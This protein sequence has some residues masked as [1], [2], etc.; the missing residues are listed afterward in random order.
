MTADNQPSTYSTEGTTVH[1][2]R[3][4]AVLSI[5]GSDSS[6]G[7]GIQADLKTMMACGLYGMTAITSLTAQNTT[8]VRAS[9][10][11]TPDM[12][13]AQID[14]VFKDIRP[15]AVKIGMVPTAELIE[16]IAQR[17]KYY[18]ANNIV[19]DPVMIASSGDRLASTAAV[20]ALTGHLLPLATLVTPN[21][22]EAETLAG[23]RHGAIHDDDSR[24]DAARRISERCNGCAVLIKGGH[25]HNGANDLLL[26][27]D[28]TTWFRHRRIVNPNTHGT[29]CTLSSAIAAE[30]AKGADLVTAVQ[31][32][33][34]YLT[35]CIAAGLDLGAG[36]GP[37]DHAWQ[38]RRDEDTQPMEKEPSDD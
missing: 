24:I 27:N 21:I 35:G 7:A 13:A 9:A 29:G 37:M 10:A 33:K 32:A 36:S 18:C 25:G 31:N 23:L 8:G 3:L 14:A 22:P 26:A 28:T 30:L 2:Y 12:L 20:D 4:P 38:W 6:G 34:D 16:I 1:P 5:A 17:L 11:T 19:V 15:D